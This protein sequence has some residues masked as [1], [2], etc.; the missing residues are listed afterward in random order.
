MTQQEEQQDTDNRKQS[1]KGLGLT[2][3]IPLIN[4]SFKRRSVKEWIE[5]VYSHEFKYASKWPDIVIIFVVEPLYPSD[6]ILVGTNMC[7][8]TVLCF[9]RALDED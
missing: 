4:L 3:R 2:I 8:A 6:G 7:G 1:T 5:G 9:N